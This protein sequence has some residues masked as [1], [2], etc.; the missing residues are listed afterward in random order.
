MKKLSFWV[1]LYIISKIVFYFFTQNTAVVE[2]YYS[3]GFYLSYSKLLN[4]MTS[5]IPF[6][7]GDL[8]YFV[9]G[10]YLLLKIIKT[11]KANT[12]IRNKAYLFILLATKC[13]VIFYLAF[14]LM[15]GLNNYRIPLQNQLDIAITYTEEDLIK[16]SHKIIN[17]VNAQQLQIT[18]DSTVA[19]INNQDIKEIYENSKYG[20]EKVAIDTKLFDFYD[21]SINSSLYSIPLTYAG[22]GGYINP[23][24]IEAQVNNKIP[25]LTM[26]VTAS[27]EISHQMGYAR[28]SDANF[29]GF[30]ATSKQDELIYQ[31]AANI[32]ALRFCLSELHKT[33]SASFESIVQR[34]SSGVLVNVNENTVF[35]QQHKNFTDEIFKNFYHLFLKANN[36]KEGLRS[37]SKF[38]ALLINYDKKTPLY[39]TDNSEVKSTSL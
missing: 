17:T 35:W 4:K 8:L 24:T 1:L 10:I 11:I 16:L 29:I 28:E 6:S 12:S 14:N 9:L 38:L 18:K 7:I 34:I 22:F 15:W 5:A 36:Q 19:V 25:K 31:Y 23:F 30:L 21:T 32:F 26:I 13:Y 2:K 3:E 37:Y 27:H 20:L 39:K 33:N